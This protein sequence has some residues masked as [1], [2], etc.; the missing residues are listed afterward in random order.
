MVTLVPLVPRKAMVWVRFS[1]LTKSAYAP[2]TLL[3]S[4]KSIPI[5][6][7]SPDENLRGAE[8]LDTNTLILPPIIVVITLSSLAGQLGESPALVCQHHLWTRGTIRKGRY[9]AL[10][11]CELV[12]QP[13]DELLYRPRKNLRERH[14]DTQV[15]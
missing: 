15:E 4:R 3:S 6:I 1:A 10:S 2:S 12:A 7:T 14:L 9:Y 13:R 5:R 11:C 8:G